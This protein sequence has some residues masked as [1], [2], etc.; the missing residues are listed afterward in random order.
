MRVRYLTGE[1][2]RLLAEESK[3][4][5]I[6]GP[7]QVGKTTL[8]KHFLDQVGAQAAY[9]NWDVEGHRRSILRDPERFWMTSLGGNVG[10]PRLGLDEIHKYPRWKRFLKGLYDAHA[11]SVDILVTGSGRLDIYQKGGDSL[12]GRYG[13]YRLHPFTV[14]EMIA[15]TRGEVPTPEAFWDSLSTRPKGSEE[16]LL[17]IE[18]FTGFPEPLFAQSDTRLARWRRAHRDL[19]VREDLRD[20]TRIRD[21]GL[22]DAM[23]EMLP[24]R[25]GSPLSLNALREDLGVAFGTAQTWLA[26]LERLYFLFEI[27]PYAGRLARTLRREG[28][29]Y[30]YD[31]TQIASLGAKFE[32]LVALHLRKLCDAW[33]DWGY[34]DFRLHYVRDKEGHEVD[35]LITQG[36]KPHALIETKLSDTAPASSLTYFQER[37]RPAHAVQIVRNLDRP[38]PASRGAPACLPAAWFLSRI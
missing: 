32:N 33:T 19:I 31:F 3:M 23:V 11:K 28:K 17:A 27:R 30:L 24:E 16:A 18:R 22:I 38:L 34:G 14:G 9:F 37:L 35:F 21:L 25:V 36:S 12:F 8:V 4:A 13:L 20:L 26:A 6:S 29:V 7:R 5:F 1:V 15:G 10:R 2:G